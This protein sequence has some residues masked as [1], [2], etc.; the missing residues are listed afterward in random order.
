MSYSG[1][2]VGVLFCNKCG[3]DRVE[4]IKKINLNKNGNLGEGISYG[5]LYNR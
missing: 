1:G 5:L 4:K 3:N 2:K